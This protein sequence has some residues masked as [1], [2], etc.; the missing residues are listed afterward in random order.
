M[1]YQAYWEYQL[2]V[3]WHGTV[4]PMAPSVRL[5][6]PG[7]FLGHSS[8]LGLIFPYDWQWTLGHKEV[9]SSQSKSFSPEECKRRVDPQGKAY[10]ITY[11]SHVWGE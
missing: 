8:C 11:W 7:L 2:D 5:L 10:A 9:C 6:A 1:L 3:D 4:Q